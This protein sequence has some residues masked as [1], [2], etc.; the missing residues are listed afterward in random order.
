MSQ[1]NII[2]RIAENKRYLL[3]LLD[4]ICTQNSGSALESTYTP[5]Y[6]VQTTSG[7]VPD[8]LQTYTIRNIGD[9]DALVG[10]QILPAGVSLTFSAY[11]DPTTNEYKRPD[12]V[13]YDPQLSS[14]G[15]STT[16]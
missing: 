1:Q 15:I 16:P 6:S 9:T 8:G 11:L 14:L 4:A 10:G 13:A 12:G 3:K 5:T 2:S 7:S